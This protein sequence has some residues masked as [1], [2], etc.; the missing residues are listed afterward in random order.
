MCSALKIGLR[1]V[2]PI[3][4]RDPLRIRVTRS[5]R[6]HH[7]H[8][9]CIYILIP[10]KALL[11]YRSTPPPI[12]TGMLKTLLAHTRKQARAHLLYEGRIYYG[13]ILYGV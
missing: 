6:T 3:R 8:I 4:S 10:L 12:H 9:I 13:P 5:S 2:S 1:C 11:Y 7:T